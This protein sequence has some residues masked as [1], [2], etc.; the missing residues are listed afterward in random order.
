[1]TDPTNTPP[2]Q[3][4]TPPSMPAPAAPAAPAPTPAAPAAPATSNWASSA[5]AAAGARPTGIT[6]LAVLAGLGGVLGSLSAGLPCSGRHPGLRRSPALCSASRALAYAGL[7]LA[8]AYGAWTL[9]PWAWPLGVALLPIFGHLVGDPPHR[10]R[11][12]HRQPVLITIVIDG[13]DPLLPQ[14]A[15]HQVAVRPR[16]THRVKRR[17]PDPGPRPSRAVVRSERRPGDRRPVRG[18]EG[19]PA[20]GEQCVRPP[21]GGPNLQP[22]QQA[23][24]G[25]AELVVQP[26]ADPLDARDLIRL[27]AGRR[28][29]PTAPCGASGRARSTPRGRRRRRAARRRPAGCGRPCGRCCS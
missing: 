25:L 11:R 5:S 22:R 21:G 24:E 12:Q 14:P 16:L 3:D 9:K 26:R 7:G 23:G 10:R 27:R 2:P 6:I 4:P 1:M 29:S 17:G 19:E 15:G 20:R 18:G 28:A 13:A 8:F